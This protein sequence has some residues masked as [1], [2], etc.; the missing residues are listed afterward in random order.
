MADT[1]RTAPA[2][3]PPTVKDKWWAIAIATPISWLAVKAFD[4]FTS[5]A[6]ADTVSDEEVAAALFWLAVGMLVLIFS[7]AALAARSRRVRPIRWTAVAAL[8]ALGIVLWLGPVGTALA[9][10]IG[11]AVCLGFD[12]P[13]YRTPR[14]ITVV[15]FVIVFAALLFVPVLALLWVLLMPYAAIG[16]SDYVVDRRRAAWLEPPAGA[17]GEGAR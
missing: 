15:L 12:G 7:F 17:E 16:V 8:S 3:P 11:G 13:H 2:R 4:S 6:T 5:R 1:E 14:I 10:P 9:L